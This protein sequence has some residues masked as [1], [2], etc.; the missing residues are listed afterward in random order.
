MSLIANHL[1]QETFIQ[2]QLCAR[3]QATV[4]YVEKKKPFVIE[5]YTMKMF[6][7]KEIYEM[8]S[9]SVWGNRTRKAF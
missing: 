1:L 7:V 3:Q 8:R 4:R 6:C 9:M 2:S 5:K